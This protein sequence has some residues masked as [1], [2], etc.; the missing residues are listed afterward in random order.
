MKK[1]MLF[2]SISP[3]NYAW[4]LIFVLPILSNRWRYSRNLLLRKKCSTLNKV[5]VLNVNLKLGR[6]KGHKHFSSTLQTREVK[7]KLWVRSLDLFFITFCEF[8]EVP[9]SEHSW[10]HSLDTLIH[11]VVEDTYLWE[12]LTSST[13]QTVVSK[14]LAK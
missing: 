11:N 6:D 3:T 4:E 1:E 10:P 12:Q 14:P 13:C 9:W 2:K 8:G 5:A 7:N